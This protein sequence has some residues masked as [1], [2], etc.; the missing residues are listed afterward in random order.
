M[1]T[2]IT[3]IP[4][5]AITKIV[6][7]LDDLDR[8]D[9][10]DEFL[11]GYQDRVAAFTEHPDVPHRIALDTWVR[12]WLFSALLGEGGA[13]D[14]PDDPGTPTTRAEARQRVA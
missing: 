12:E 5:T 11:Q 8:A 6:S 1:T 2:D 14:L 9:L 7:V 3:G 4:K 13:A 10:R